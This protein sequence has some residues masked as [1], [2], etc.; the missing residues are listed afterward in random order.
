MGER[1]V[2][3]LIITK[4]CPFVPLMFAV[5][6]SAVRT[7]EGTTGKT[8]LKVTFPELGR[9]TEISSTH[10]SRPEGGKATDWQP[11]QLRH[12]RLRGDSTIKSV[13]LHRRTTR[14]RREHCV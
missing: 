9:V 12:S 8:L 11:K 4:V 5:R 2:K 3:I 14:Q 13:F 7:R 10:T 6:P 1:Y